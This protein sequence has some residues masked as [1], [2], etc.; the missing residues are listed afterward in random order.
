[1]HRT[2]VLL[3]LPLV[4]ARAGRLHQRT[5]CVRG[6]VAG[7][8]PSA[9]TVWTVTSVGGR[10]SMRRTRR[11]WTSRPTAGSAAR[12]AQPVHGTY[13]LDGTQSRSAQLR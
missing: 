5:G 2:L 4:L 1:M 10:S 11:R 13:T 12:P 6:P 8:R 3:A 9:G 7:G